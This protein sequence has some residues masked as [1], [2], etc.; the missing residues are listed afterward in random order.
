VPEAKR[1]ISSLIFLSSPPDAARIIRPD[2]VTITRRC[3]FLV[4]LPEKNRE[5]FFGASNSPLLFLDVGLC[6]AAEERTTKLPN[7]KIRS[8]FLLSTG[9]HSIS[10]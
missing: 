1:G 9:D 7:F 3:R 4:A 5:N 8:L 2:E 10:S 6:E